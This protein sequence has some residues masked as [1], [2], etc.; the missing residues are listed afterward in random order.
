MD[1][2]NQTAEDVLRFLSGSILMKDFCL[3]GGTALA[4]QINKRMSDDLDF[5]IWQDR[6][7]TKVYEIKWTKIE[8]LLESEFSSVRKDLIDLQQVNFIV[9]DVKLTFFVRDNVNSSV[10]QSIPLIND[11]ACANIESIGAMKLEL[12]QRRNL[13]RD[14]ILKSYC[15]VQLNIQSID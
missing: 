3:V 15:A 13:Y 8:E 1:G 9:N 10:I 7:G 6:V 5:C 11:I 14:I 12:L 4:I 2:I